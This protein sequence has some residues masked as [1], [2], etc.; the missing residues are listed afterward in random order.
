MASRPSWK[1]PSVTGGNSSRWPGRRAN[2]FNSGSEAVAV[3][4]PAAPRSIFKDQRPKYSR[5]M[6]Q[7][8]L[9]PSSRC[10]A[11]QGTHCAVASP[12][13]LRL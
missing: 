2:D 5:A 3:S 11:V 1:T 7:P 13:S 10:K 9:A 8:S 4:G 6:N 12:S